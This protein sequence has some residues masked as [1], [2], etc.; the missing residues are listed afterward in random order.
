MNIVLFVDS[1]WRD[2][3]GIALVKYWIKQL[4][5]FAKVYT[6]SFDLWQSVLKINPDVVVLNHAFGQRNQEILKWARRN[7]ATSFLMF[8]EGRPNTDSQVEW[9]KGQIGKSDYILSWSDWLSEFFD[10]AI[11]VGCPR[12]DIYQEPYRKLIKPREFV[13][14]QYGLD[15]DKETILIASSFPQAK[16]SYQGVKFNQADWKDLD[17]TTIDGREDPYAFAQREQDALQEFRL[18]VAYYASHLSDDYQVIVK[19]HPMENQFDWARYCDE[20]GFTLVQHE[21]IFNLLNA[22]DLLINRVGCLTTQDSWLLNRDKEVVQLVMD[23]DS[24]TGS[25]LEAYEESDKELFLD[26]YG[27]SVKES[28]KKVAEAILNNSKA[29]VENVPFV[30]LRKYL[31]AQAQYDAHYSYP[32]LSL[33]HPYKGTPSNVIKNWEIEIHNILWGKQ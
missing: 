33:M 12:F 27:F 21:Y 26:K 2:S 14:D 13:L 8:T 22:S 11:T 23:D 29:K 28:G 7:G 5:P 32:D 24:P 1:R 17:V 31:E 10:N 19:P 3:F 20:N 4:S 16:F 6:P 9:Y 18:K 30:L 15:A 25:S